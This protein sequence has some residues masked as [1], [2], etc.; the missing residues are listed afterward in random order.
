MECFHTKRATKLGH[1]WAKQLA[2]KA[3]LLEQPNE[4]RAVSAQNEH[5]LTENWTTLPPNKTRSAVKRMGP[6][7]LVKPYNEDTANVCGKHWHMVIRRASQ[8]HK[9]GIACLGKSSPMRNLSGH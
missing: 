3:A 6:K 4:L 8:R 7:A 1:G 5:C 2:K 9:H